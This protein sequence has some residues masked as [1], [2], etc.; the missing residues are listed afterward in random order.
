MQW[1][2]NCYYNLKIV[3]FIECNLLGIKFMILAHILLEISLHL[4]FLMNIF[5][6]ILPYMTYVFKTALSHVGN[7]F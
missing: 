1:E 3:A 5:A 6:F 4:D 7:K 2:N